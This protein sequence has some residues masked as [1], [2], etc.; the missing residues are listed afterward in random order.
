VQSGSHWTAGTLHVDGTHNPCSRAVFTG[1]WP[2]MR[3]IKIIAVDMKLH[4]VKLTDQITRHETAWH[5]IAGLKNRKCSFV[6]VIFFNTLRY[7]A[8]CVNE[9]L[10][11]KRQYNVAKYKQQVCCNFMSRIFM[12]GNFSPAIS[13][14]AIS[15]QS[16]SAPTSPAPQYRACLTITCNKYLTPWW[17]GLA[18]KPTHIRPILSVYQLL[19]C[20]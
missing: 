10:L 13:C 6:V 14:P 15:R 1:A 11:K 20:C 3:T 4:D 9:C 5:K 12:S 2:K 16:F 19:I 8:L 7:D 17:V 18:D